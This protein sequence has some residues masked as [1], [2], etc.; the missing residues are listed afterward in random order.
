MSAPQTTADLWVRRYRRVTDAALRLVCFPHAGGSASFFFP[1]ATALAD[2]GVEVLAVQ[3]PGRQDRRHEKPITDLH[4]LADA[5]AETLPAAL[6]GWD[7]A[8]TAFFGH[9]M[10]AA[11][12]FEVARRMERP[13]VK[14]VASGRRAP[15]RRRAESVHLRDDAGVVAELRA[16]GGTEASLLEDAELLAMLLPAVRGDYAAIE[17]YACAPGAAVDTP[18]TVFVGDDDPHVTLDEARA[19]REHTTGGFD[20]HVFEGG[21]F[22]LTRSPAE[23]IERLATTIDMRTSIS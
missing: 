8:P 11:L 12:A 20:M 9:S 2:R 17:T 10:G 15:S 5:V 1:V 6:P 7:G 3:Y 22:Y 14:L 23:T 19:W 21:H 13:P 18:I 4:R 16:L